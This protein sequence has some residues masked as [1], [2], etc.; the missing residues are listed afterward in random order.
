MSSHRQ[1]YVKTLAAAAACGVIAVAVIHLV[2]RTRSG[3]FE[4]LVEVLAAGV[5]AIAAGVVIGGLLALYRDYSQAKAAMDLFYASNAARSEP[6]LAAGRAGMGIVLRRLWRRLLGGSWLLVGDVV[7]IRSIDEIGKTLD[8]DRC[9]DRLP[10]MPEMARFCGQRA[11]VFRCVDKIY[12]YGRS[13]TLRRLED[14]V[15]LGGLRCDGTSHGGCQASCYLLWKRTWLKPV[16]EAGIA[17]GRTGHPAPA[18][19]RESAPIAD[20]YSCQYTQLAAAS[21]PMATW[22]VRQDLR[23]L[24]SGNVTLSAFLVAMLTRLFNA[25]QQARGG[26]EYPSL[27]PG[28]QSALPSPERDLAPGD[29]V[30][31][32]PME[33]IAITLDQGG[34]HRGLWF[35]R[36]MVKHCGRRYSVLRR[37]DRIID[38]A[39]GRMLELKRPSL[40]LA[41]A[42][43]SGEFLRFCAQHEY[44]FWRQ[45]WLSPDPGD[46]AG[47]A[48]P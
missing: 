44:P 15:L 36:D 39:T 35:D 10:F 25:V 48:A 1:S 31:V 32:R 18:A 40:V 17:R 26:V 4:V 19:W 12:D 14:A 22:D 28:P 27:M 29:R 41:G 2:G 23:P 11:W 13:K 37:V 38:D 20:Q 7:E 45:E 34:R 24:A 16:A 6:V 30:R 3:V 46:P 5:L 21:T 8:G 42:E 33:D 47:P 43:A 9:L